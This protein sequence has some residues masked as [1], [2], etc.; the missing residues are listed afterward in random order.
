MALRPWRPTSIRGSLV[1][2]VFAAA[3]LAFA[4]AAAGLLLFE[5]FTLEGRVRAIVEPYAQIVSVGAETAIAFSDTERAQEILDSLRAHPQILGAQIV[6]PGGR[7]LARLGQGAPALAEGREDGVLLAPNHNTAELVRELNDG[8]RL[9]LVLD[10]GG[11][12][13]EARNTLLALSAATVALLA[14]V[15]LGVLV[16][17]QRAIVQPVS[18]LAAAVDQVR[19]G[20][21]YTR[22][23]P[24]TG[25]DEVARLGDGFNAMMATVQQR[26]EALHGLTALQRTILDNVGSPIISATPDGIVTSFNPAAERLLGYAAREV[27]GRLTPQVWHE[28][29][30]V[31]RRARELS[32]EL[33]ELVEPSFEVFVARPRRGQHEVGDWTC[34]CK[35]GRRVPVTLIVTALR[36]EA[37]RITGYVGLLTDLTERKRAEEALRLH[38]DELEAT[39]RQRTVELQ[40]ARDAAEAA[41][42]A[43]SAFLA[44]MSHEIRTPMNAIMGM[45]E[46][47]LR[48]GLPPQQHDYVRKAH[49]A[50]E[51]LLGILNDILDFSK[52]EAGRLE[53]ECIPF[54]LRDVLDK[55]VSLVGMKAEERGIELLLALPPRLP[56]T[57]HGD[58]SRLQQVLLNLAGNAV[59]FTEGGEVVIGIELLEEGPSSV[60]LG[61]EVSDTGVGMTPEVVERLFE[62]FAQG[63][64]STSRRYGGTGLGLAISRE[65]LHLMGGELQVRSEPS[66]GSRFSFAL[67]FDCDE[68]AA[69]TAP[70][71]ADLRGLRML[72]VDDNARALE[73]IAGMGRALDLE[74]D[75]AETAETALR[76]V[77]QADAASAPYALLVVDAMMPDTDGVACL[78]QL[79]RVPLGQAPKVV[80]TTTTFACDAL[81]DRL[82]AEGLSPAALLAKPVTPAA[83]DD[84][85]RA[86]LGRAPQHA[87]HPPLREA[88]PPP[89]LRDVRVLLVEDNEINREI[90][91]TLLGG[92]GMRVRVAGDGREALQILSDERFDVVLMDCQMPVMDGYEATRALRSRPELRQLPVIAMTANAMVGDRE[93]ALAAGMN[94]HIAKPIRVD[95]LFATLARW[96]PPAARSA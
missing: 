38:K 69:G 39:V 54:T 51:S 41:N 96:L 31:A 5:R 85:C 40:V 77:V 80:L 15:T 62:P 74:V 42:R 20:A 66:R 11:L 70:A 65:L 53:L 21:D 27:I 76:R 60:R 64:A 67:R 57:L 33:G 23:V 17:L 3:L 35:D 71:D 78:H 84:A 56:Q 12:R 47:A 93:E 89:D 52:V 30:E 91:L 79:A 59:K 72:L 25:R 32:A 29:D 95:R 24:A 87:A 75:T 90:A 50:A 1:A 28:P 46:L 88:A 48:S 45:S 19:V 83:L 7:V 36:D 4:A 34:V 9:Q 94:D 55:L 14:M 61:F 18:A 92:A 37:S 73:L 44:N 10:L 43:K 26:D 16:V 68:A 81:T 63:D 2:T 58:P 6:L 13:R 82:A 86:A 49:G 8:A 22:R